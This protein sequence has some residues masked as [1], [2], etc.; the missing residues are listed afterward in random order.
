M[1]EKSIKMAMT[2]APVGAFIREE[3]FKPLNLR[4]SR[5]AEITRRQAPDLVGHRQRQG[6]AQPG[7]RA[8]HREGLRRVDGAAPAHPNSSRSRQ[9]PRE[10]Q[11]NRSAEIRAGVTGGW[12]R[13][14]K[15]VGNAETFILR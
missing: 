9:G 2:P 10:R 13:H 14:S 11:Q 7:G 8:P 6:S 12:P 1:S 15:P 4:I 5:A 3:I